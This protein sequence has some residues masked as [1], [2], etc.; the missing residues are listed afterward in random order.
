MAGTFLPWAA[1]LLGA[2]LFAGVI[3][4]EV[5]W[6]ARRGWATAGRGAAYAATTDILGFCIGAGIMFVLAF[7]MF[8]M[9]MG[10]AGRG[11]SS[12]EWLYWAIACIAVTV[13][14]VLF[15]FTKR[16]GLVPFKIGPGGKSAWIYSLV[17]T[18]S[19]IGVLA[20]PP[21]IFYLLANLLQWK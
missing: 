7:L 19:M 17:I 9:V 2:L 18:V 13:P 4:L 14:I 5:R 8:M 3:L 11:G 12:P 10:P 15:F 6:L 21:A 1:F 20:V 16:L